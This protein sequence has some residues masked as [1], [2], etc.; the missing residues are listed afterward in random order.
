MSAEIHPAAATGFAR[1]A[2]AYARGRPD[3]PDAA[4]D[5]LA[6]RIGRRVVDLA[7]GT[8]ML[9][10]ALAARGLDVVAVEP[11]AEMRALI[12]P[13]GGVRVLAGT[14]EAIP[15]GDA[16]ADGVTVAQ[17][18]HWFDGPRALAEIARV[19]RPGGAL[20]LVYN[21]RRLQ[22]AIHLRIQELLE[23]Y[24]GDVP[25]GRAGAWRGAVETSERF[26][27]AA[28]ATFDNAQRLDGDGLA[29]RFGSVSFVA[30]L[31]EPRRAALLAELRELAGGASA[32]LRYRTEVEILRRM[33]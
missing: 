23:P 18:F 30:A 26:E 9:T 17:A 1:A 27:P 21:H 4:V 8:G 7:A 11:I 13:G 12:A 14:A 2:A 19:L 6:A 24:R 29:D 22:D 16:S 28:S 3:Y 31:D 25:A 5:W 15:A 20:A 32:T 33:G 10:R